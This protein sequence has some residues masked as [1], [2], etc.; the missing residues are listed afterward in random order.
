MEEE[1][2]SPPGRIKKT[3]D[4]VSRDDCGVR[5]DLPSTYYRECVLTADP[6]SN[7]KSQKNCKNCAASPDWVQ[8]LIPH[9]QPL[10]KK[11]NSIPSSS[12]MGNQTSTVSTSSSSSAS[13]VDLD[14]LRPFA[15]GSLG[16]S[17]NELDKRCI[18]SGYVPM[19][20]N[21]KPSFFLP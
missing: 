12:T 18:P 1:R 7:Q 6:V 16:L 15:R 5:T 3:W 4:S 17:R 11:N 13:Q 9:T 21:S 8:F 14:R 20:I 10:R 2:R 19:L